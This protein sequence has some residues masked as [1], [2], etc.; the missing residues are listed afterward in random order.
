MDRLAR[1]VNAFAITTL[2]LFDAVRRRVVTLQESG[3]TLSTMFKA[4]TVNSSIDELV[5]RQNHPEVVTMNLSRR[6]PNPNP[7]PNSNFGV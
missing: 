4:I 6:N 1:R 5:A 2:F 7:H 3:L